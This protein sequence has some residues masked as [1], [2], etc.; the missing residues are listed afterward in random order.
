M[1]AVLAMAAALAVAPCWAFAQPAE[2]SLPDSSAPA[3]VPAPSDAALRAI[4]EAALKAKLIDPYSAVIEWSPKPFLSI[5]RLTQGAGIFKHTIA[6]GPMSA[7]CGAV[8]AKNRMGGYVGSEP[9]YVVIKDG[10]AISV[11]MDSP[12][13]DDL[14][15]AANLCRS[16]GF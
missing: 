15:I 10:S 1:K 12:D 14:H 4:G 9:F 8:N 2:N 3:A 13:A 16:M 5:D 6:S 11:V 7:G